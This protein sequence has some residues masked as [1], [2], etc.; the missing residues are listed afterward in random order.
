VDDDPTSEE[1][2][3][4]VQLRVP[5]RPGVMAEPEPIPSQHRVVSV[6]RQFLNWK[7]LAPTVALMLT[8]AAL[9]T[10][11][12]YESPGSNPDDFEQ[13]SMLLKS[14]RLRKVSRPHQRSSSL[15]AILNGTSLIH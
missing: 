7:V 5:S 11:S 8:V 12:R 14:G 2:K 3:L 9:N 4:L 6:L 13:K 15:R 1:E 10:G